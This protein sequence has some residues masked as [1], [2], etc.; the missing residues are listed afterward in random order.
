MREPCAQ[1]GGCCRTATTYVTASSSAGRWPSARRS[2]SLHLPVELRRR[3]GCLVR[4][5]HQ[6]VGHLHTGRAGLTHGTQEH[7]PQASRRC[8]SSCHGARPEYGVTYTS[9]R[10][11][12][13]MSRDNLRRETMRSTNRVV[14]RVRATSASG[15]PLR[16]S[17]VS[18]GPVAWLRRRRS[19]P[20]S[21]VPPEAKNTVCPSGDQTGVTLSL[22]KVSLV[23]GRDPADSRHCP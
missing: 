16:V 3:F 20:G 17:S 14:A 23:S 1:A 18:T 7:E 11:H 13:T 10:G 5:M 6:L 15:V 21:C 22:S 8:R 9:S 2:A 4:A 12:P 19:V